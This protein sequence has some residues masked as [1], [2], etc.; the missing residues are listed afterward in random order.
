MERPMSGLAFEDWIGWLGV[1]VLIA[2]VITPLCWKP[3]EHED[4]GP[5]RSDDP[6][7]PPYH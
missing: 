7:P 3:D 6:N 4:P 2:L 1:L 5:N